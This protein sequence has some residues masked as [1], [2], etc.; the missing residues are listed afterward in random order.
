MKKSDVNPTETETFGSSLEG[1]GFPLPL[2]RRAGNESI[3]WTIA[4]FDPSGGAG[5]TADL[6]TFAAHSLFGCSAITALTVQSTLGVFGTELVRPELLHDS[7]QRLGED[8]PPR[9]VKIGMLGGTE[10]ARV[11]GE[12]LGGLEQK[13]PVVLDPVLRSSSGRDLYPQS[14]LGVLHQDLLPR[15]QWV[16]PNWMELEMLSRTAIRNLN[17]AEE[18]A[19]TLQTRHPEL[20]VVVTGGDQESPVDLLVPTLGDAVAFSGEHIETNAT[21]GTGCAFSSALLAHLVRGAAPAAAV[22]GAKRYVEGGLRH[23]P[24]IGG[25]RGPMGLLWPLHNRAAGDDVGSL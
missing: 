8:L 20:N 17:T 14:G 4:G 12:F 19:R 23:A 21:H 7:L 16:T 25:G 22:R 18:A 5:I 11:I 1:A 13:G 24:G 15:V 10:T 3:V 6:M 2:S 9:G